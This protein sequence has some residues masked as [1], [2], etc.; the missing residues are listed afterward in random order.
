MAFIF[1][2]GEENDIKI[3]FDIQN[4]KDAHHGKWGPQVDIDLQIETKV[5]RYK[6]QVSIDD[7]E[8]IDLVNTIFRFSRGEIKEYYEWDHI[9]Q[10]IE[11]LFNPKDDAIRILIHFTP[12]ITHL[13]GFY[14]ELWGKDE[15][16]DFY[17]YL[18]EATHG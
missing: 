2:D 12:S 13:S 7:Y 11:V 4:W 10:D 14:F 9:E 17:K 16:M 18:Y 6:K 15:Y 5:F 1:I 3:S 8:L